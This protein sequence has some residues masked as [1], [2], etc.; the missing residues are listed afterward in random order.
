MDPLDFFLASPLFSNHDEDI[1][2][3]FLM[4][5]TILSYNHVTIR[6]HLF[7]WIYSKS[8]HYWQVVHKIVWQAT[9]EMKND[10]WQQKY[11]MGYQS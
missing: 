5:C 8:T 11:R 9:Y 4:F 7:F 1:V 10:M 2:Q 6:S 3:V